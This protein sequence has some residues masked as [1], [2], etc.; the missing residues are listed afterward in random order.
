MQ[1]ARSRMTRPNEL[2]IARLEPA[3]SAVPGDRLLEAGDGGDQRF[4]AEV[5]RDPVVAADPV[6]LLHL[7]DLVPVEW[8]GPGKDAVQ[9]ACGGAGR[10]EQAGRNSDVERAPVEACGE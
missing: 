10:G 5:G 8:K 3:V 6:R 9:G 2:L 7:E 4:P 1:L